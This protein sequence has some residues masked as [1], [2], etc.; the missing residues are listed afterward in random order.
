MWLTG[1]TVQ[2][3]ATVAGDTAR[4]A[5]NWWAATQ[6]V[7]ANGW[8][9]IKNIAIK[10]WEAAASVYASIASIPY[11][12][13]FLAPVMAVAAT[14]MVLGFAGHI[15]SARGGYDI[16]AGVNPVTQLHEREMVL[17]QKQADAVR[18]MADNG[19]SA[20]G[21]THL[22][23]HATDADSVR[24]LFLNNKGAV[25]DAVRSALRDFRR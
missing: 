3:S 24:R 10:A 13:P 23:V 18:Q 14:G 15:A 19:G 6:S 21:E 20:G 9:A 25:A 4:T 17:P 5:S 11:V 7:M 16:P 12:G 22:H 2:T 1:E 8:A